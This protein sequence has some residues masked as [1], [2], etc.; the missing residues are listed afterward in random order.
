MGAFHCIRLGDISSLSLVGPVAV[1][2]FTVCTSLSI[3][4]LIHTNCS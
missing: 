4:I 1:A 3:L 2:A